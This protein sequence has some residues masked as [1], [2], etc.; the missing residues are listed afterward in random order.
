MTTTAA[1]SPTPE[2][3]LDLQ[4]L[5]AGI[6]W[7]RRLCGSVA[8][9]GLLAGALLAILV[10]PPPT[11]VTRL[12]VVH[13]NDNPSD[14][15]SI[16]ET[17]V[18]VLQ[19]ARIA[20]AALKAIDADERPESFLAD[21]QGVGLTNNIL[22]I[23]VQGSSNR[24]AVIRA[25]ALADAFIDDHV[26]RAEATANAEAKA[27][28]ERRDK[29]EE[30]LAK[31]DASIAGRT[32]GEAGGTAAELT[33]LYARRA[34]LAAQIQ[35]LGKRAEEAQIGAPHV[36]VGT[37]IVDAP[38][39]IPHSRIA[40]AL[41]NSGVGLFLGLMV[42]LVL[43]AVA[44]LVQDRPV[45]RRD[46]AAHLGASVIAQLSKPRRRYLPLWR[47]TRSV[48]ERKRVATTLARLIRDAPAGVSLLELGCP[49]IAAQLAKNIAEEIAVDRPV[50]LVDD[51]PVRNRPR[52]R[53]QTVVPTRPMSIPQRG[54]HLGLGSVAPG[55]AWTDLGHLGGETVLVVRAGF[56]NTL[57]LH[58][59]ARQLADAQ[60][61]VI[62]VVLVHPDPRDRTDGT[63]WDGLH[64]ALRG[65]TSR[66]VGSAPDSVPPGRGE[67]QGHAG[68]PVFH[69]G[70]RRTSR[71]DDHATEK[72][73]PVRPSPP[74]NVEVS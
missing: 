45:L 33:S 30:D 55:T 65:R 67:S 39:A 27:L 2:P 1:T 9:I 26:K 34:E 50:V 62:G 40:T 52:P 36:A 14:A 57:W 42:G 71:T 72:F 12:L 70:G 54:E 58:T 74:E 37:Q 68:G 56:A 24:D 29:A 16:M 7:R 20:A 53:R 59:V 44:S 3:L 19:T 35:D 60:I 5:V 13:V 11:A 32:A 25:K 10:P 31:V 22:E 47:R 49:R 46:I 4:R 17:D 61:S 15:G 64:T 18:A 38:R 23:T 21:Y 43:A 41:L 69:G 28:S 66:P 51:L 8:L 63:L 6:R 73:P 48:A